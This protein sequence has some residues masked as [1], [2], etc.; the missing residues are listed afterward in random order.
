MRSLRFFRGMIDLLSYTTM[1]LFGS[2]LATPVNMSQS[3]VR[4]ARQ[5]GCGA[6]VGD[7]DRGAA[8]GSPLHSTGHFQMQS[9]GCDDWESGTLAVAPAGQWDVLYRPG[10]ELY[11]LDLT[12]T[13]AET[14]WRGLRL[15]QQHAWK[16]ALGS[17][18]GSRTLVVLGGSMTKGHGTSFSFAQGVRQWLQNATNLPWNLRNLAVGAMPT[19]GLLPTLPYTLRVPLDDAGNSTSADVLLVDC[20]VNDDE[21]GGLP[22]WGSK[23]LSRPPSKYEQLLAATEALVQFVLKHHPSTALLLVEGSCQAIADYDGVAT[24]SERA[25]LEVARHYGVAALAF[26]RVLKRGRAACA[27]SASNP[28]VWRSNTCANVE[29]GCGPNTHPNRL[30]HAYIADSVGGLLATFRGHA[31]NGTKLIARAEGSHESIPPSLVQDPLLRQV[32]GVCAEP[33]TVYDALRHPLAMELATHPRQSW[34][35]LSDRE[36]KPGWISTMEGAVIDFRVQ[37]GHRPRITISWTQGY[38]NS[39]GRARVTMTQ[40]GGQARHWDEL[41][42]LHH[43]ARNVTQM[44][45]IVW[46]VGPASEW[47]MRAGT[48][49]AAAEATV[50]IELLC[51]LDALPQG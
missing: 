40:Q 23:L 7:G 17:S 21:I 26:A 9:V 27:P 39:W 10:M 8:L 38:D 43:A 5:A 45:T 33:L 31:A 44:N 2:R 3:S 18:G 22:P 11:P 24:S 30:A 13:A 47:G 29:T 1:D 25:K 20:S 15:A 46:L 32:F 41:D 16:V 51:R 37:L 50:R 42:G 12:R 49:S 36:G 35:L 28:V 6:Q 34:R 48:A 14:P 4:A 19:R